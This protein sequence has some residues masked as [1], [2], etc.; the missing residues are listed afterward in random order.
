MSRKK[1]N[2]LVSFVYKL[3]VENRIPIIRSGFKTILKDKEGNDSE[4]IKKNFIY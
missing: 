4:E 3:T 2:M 1:E